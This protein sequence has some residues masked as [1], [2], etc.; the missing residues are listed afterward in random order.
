MAKDMTTAES[1]LKSKIEAWMSVRNIEKWKQEHHALFILSLAA[2][3]G[4]KGEELKKF[5]EQI[6]LC[7][8]AGNCSQMELKFGWRKPK[9]EVK[10]SSLAAE[11][12][13][14][15]QA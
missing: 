12:A 6:S 10:G 2:E 7:G 9:E 11:L 14:L 4:M 5:G 15:A 8:L 3:C 1:A 13:R